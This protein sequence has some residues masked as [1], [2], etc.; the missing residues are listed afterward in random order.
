MRGGSGSGGNRSRFGGRITY[1]EQKQQNTLPTSLP[2]KEM[3]VHRKGQLS[4]AF[5]AASVQFAFVLLV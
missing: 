4:V 1:F 3:K 2:G 5:V